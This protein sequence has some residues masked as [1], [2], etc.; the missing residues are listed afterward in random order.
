MKSIQTRYP[1]ADT[2]IKEILRDMTDAGPTAITTGHWPLDYVT[3]NDWRKSTSKNKSRDWLKFATAAYF[4]EVF[5]PDYRPALFQESPAAGVLR[6]ALNTILSQHARKKAVLVR[7][8]KKTDVVQRYIFPDGLPNVEEVTDPTEDLSD[9]FNELS[10]SSPATNHNRGIK[11]T[12]KS[13]LK[14]PSAH[15]TPRTKKVNPQISSL[16]SKLEKVR[17][18]SW[19]L[20]YI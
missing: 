1:G 5:V 2:K 17:V 16:V 4:E 8:T 15:L 13:I 14:L 10:W 6:S 20:S 19:G 12:T 11:T 3:Y 9:I 7:G 18:L